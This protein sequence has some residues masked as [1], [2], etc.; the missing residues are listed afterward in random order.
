MGMAVVIPSRL[1]EYSIAAFLII[2]AP[3]PSVLFTIAR[4][5]AWGRAI[6]IFTVIGNILGMYTMAVI[7]SFGLS[8]ILAKSHL[9]FTGVHWLGGLYLIYLG[10]SAIKESPRDAEDMLKIVES[11]PSAA[12]TIRQGYLVGALNPKGFVFFAAILPQF[13][14]RDRGSI[15]FQMLLMSTIFAVIGFIS[16]GS[17][18]F[19]AGTVRNWFARD[20]KRLVRLRI[21]GGCVMILLGL[22]TLIN[23]LH[24]K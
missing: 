1:W 6:A 18:G 16:D 19:L 17:W 7:V 15:T 11:K 21:S 14:D 22:L 13:I 9:A 5:I 3:G 4:A 23:S 10:Y 2:L 20:V 8:P 12:K 24:S